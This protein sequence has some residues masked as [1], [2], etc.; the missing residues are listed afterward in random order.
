MRKEGDTAFECS[1][2]LA[3]AKLEDLIEK[4]HSRKTAAHHL[5]ELYEIKAGEE[6]TQIT[7]SD[8]GKQWSLLPTKKKRC[9]LRKVF[10]PL[11]KR[12]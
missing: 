11:E 12:T 6:L 10:E 4:G 2:T 9:V 5:H 3:T 7:Q 8:L 1:R